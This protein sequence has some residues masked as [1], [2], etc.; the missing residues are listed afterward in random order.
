MVFFFNKHIIFNVISNTVTVFVKFKNTY[1]Q[2]INIY[3][4]LFFKNQMNTKIFK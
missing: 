3:F 1:V 4:K 2:D